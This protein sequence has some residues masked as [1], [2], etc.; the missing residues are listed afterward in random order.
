M[1]DIDQSSVLAA[2]SVAAGL[3]VAGVVVTSQSTE[4]PTS[5][6]PA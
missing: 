2:L 1:I 4:A 6:P 3:T 5:G